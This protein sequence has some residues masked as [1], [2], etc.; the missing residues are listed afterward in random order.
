VSLF[1]SIPRPTF[2]QRPAFGK[3]AQHQEEAAPPGVFKGRAA[4]RR[5][6]MIRESRD[7]LKAGLPKP[8]ESLHTLLLGRVDLAVLLAAILE[9]YPSPCRHLRISTLSYAK[10]NIIEF[11]TLLESGKVGRLTLLASLFFER[12]YPELTAWVAAELAPFS[13]SVAAYR[14]VHTKLALFSFEDGGALVC[15]TSANAR[16]NGN[17]EQLAL[18]NDSA[19]L[20]WYAAWVDAKVSEV[21]AQ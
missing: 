15:E 21:A 5:M 11:L 9:Q 3:I 16:S 7:L 4:A 17:V 20:D 2:S 12:H 6:E 10:R 19:L 14:R 13:D 18:V 8:G 1:T